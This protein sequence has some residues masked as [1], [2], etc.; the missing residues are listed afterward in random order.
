[1]AA[2][3]ELQGKDNKTKTL[4]FV[5]IAMHKM[6]SFGDKNDIH[7]ACFYY[8]TII[9]LQSIAEYEFKDEVFTAILDATSQSACARLRDFV[10]DGDVAKELKPTFEAST[11]V[12]QPHLGPFA[13][14][15]FL[16][17]LLFPNDL[18]H[19][20]QYQ[21]KPLEAFFQKVGAKPDLVQTNLVRA[22]VRSDF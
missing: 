22:E 4:A 15:H 5:D 19:F 8:K 2:K 12:L 9:L 7:D 6:N 10:A 21:N 16:A 1:N 20:L 17:Y 3:K 14:V 18:K 11:R 13:K